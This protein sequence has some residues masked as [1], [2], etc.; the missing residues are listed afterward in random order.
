[1]SSKNNIAKNLMFSSA[2]L[3]VESFFAMVMSIIIAR[4]LGPESYG[5]YALIVWICALGIRIT[6]GGVGTALIKF[7][8]ESR[9]KYSENILPTVKYLKKIQIIKLSIVLVVFLIFYISFSEI[10][11]E[12]IS[13]NIFILLLLVVLLRSFSNFY[14]SLSKG[15]ENFKAVAAISV[16]ASPLHLG[17]VASAAL[18]SNT[19]HAFIIVYVLSAGVYYI[20]S[21]IIVLRWCEYEVNTIELPVVMKERVNKHVKIVMINTLL[22][23][24]ITNESELLFLKYFASDED[25]GYFKVAHRLALAIALLV[26]GIFEGIMLPLMSG[27]IAHSKDMAILKFTQSMRYVLWLAVPAGVFFAIFSK[28]IIFILYGAA[29][30]PAV[31]PFT[32]LALTCCFCSVASVPTSYLLSVD[33]QSLIL[34]VMLYGTALKLSLDYYLV[35][36]YGLYGAAIA[37]SIAFSFMFLANL[38]IAMRHL[39]VSFPWL[40]WGKIITATLIAVGSVYLVKYFPLENALV[41]LIVSAIV[42]AITYFISSLFLQCLQDQEVQSIRGLIASKNLKILKPIDWLLSSAQNSKFK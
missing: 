14:V 25:L 8:S 23:F 34:K 29:Y 33:K 27:S 17:L 11:I 39:G 42:F 3:Y 7:V 26:P 13:L 15:F 22:L 32:I 18:I 2:G 5:N 21:R 19:L 9:V 41:G 37:F 4:T 28:D 38:I 12:D 20:V 16:I 35:S 6:N 24:L 30:E 10:F 36:K 31:L 1:M 40:H